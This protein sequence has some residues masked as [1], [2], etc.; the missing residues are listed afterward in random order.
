MSL[1]E[2][3]SWR[4]ATKKYD[5]SKKVSTED[6][7]KI[8]EAARLAPTSSGLQQ[9]RV[10]LITNQELKEK[11]VPVAMDQQIIADCSHLLVFAAWDQYTEERIDEI[12]N[13]TTDEREL[14]R[15]RFSSYTDRLKSLYLQQ[16][17]EENFVHTARQ[18]YIGFGLAIAQAAELKIDTT[19]VE[20]FNNQ[21]LDELLGLTEKGLK[22][23]TLLPIG[24][25]DNEGDWLVNMKKV[26]NPLSEFIIEYN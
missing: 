1:L 15:G 7:H 8:I 14:P 11:I 6:V 18:A 25:R 19:P 24:Y 10:L 9:F 20:G 23:V 3:L 2:D 21:Q 17:A 16:S 4:Y 22:S 5:P 12:Y 13:R 26:R